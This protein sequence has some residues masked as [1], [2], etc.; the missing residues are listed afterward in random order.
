[1]YTGSQVD[2]FLGWHR[3]TRTE[4]IKDGRL[5]VRRLGGPKSRPRFL[6]ADIMRLQGRDP[7]E[8]RKGAA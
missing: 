5:V 4:A 3:H 2:Y 6:G 1:L 7:D 8:A